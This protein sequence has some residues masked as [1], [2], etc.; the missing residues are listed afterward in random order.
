L[1]KLFI[2]L[3]VASMIFKSW[4][5]K[6]FY[7]T[8]NVM[9]D[10]DTVQYIVK[11]KCSVGRFGDGELEIMNGVWYANSFQKFDKRLQKKLKKIKNSDKFLVC[12]PDVFNPERFNPKNITEFEYNYWVINKKRF[13]GLWYKFTKKGSILGDTEFTRFYLRKNDKSQ[14]GSYINELKKIW[15]NRD[16]I[17]VEGEKS[18][19]GIGND[20]FDNAKTIKR[21]LCPATNAFDSYD[22]IFATVLKHAHNDCL[23]IL[24]LGQTATVLAKDISDSGF[25]AIDMGHVDIEYEWYL[26]KAEKKIA[27]PGKYVNEVSYGRNPED[28][29]S[30]LYLSQIIDRV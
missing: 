20:L 10:A 7:K 25:Q 13:G 21:I 26:R 11:N 19:V 16:V 3:K 17:F 22:K 6:L 1:K 5:Y 23:F 2:K 9:S 8:P 29:T 14:M 18:R 4:I 28:E 30:E 15:D 24:A 27:I 12:I